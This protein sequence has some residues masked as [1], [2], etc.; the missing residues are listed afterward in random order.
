MDIGTIRTSPGNDVV[1]KP[2]LRITAALMVT[3]ASQV[4]CAE[5][6]SHVGASMSQAAAADEALAIAH[7]RDAEALLAHVDD[8]VMVGHGMESGKEWF[9][10]YFRPEDPASSFWDH[11]ITV[12]AM[13]PSGTAAEMDGD[14]ACYPPQAMWAANWISD[15][16]TTDIA[17]PIGSAVGVWSE[18]STESPLLTRAKVDALFRLLEEVNADWQRVTIVDSEFSGYVRRS[19]IRSASSRFLC[20]QVDDD[21]WKITDYIFY[22]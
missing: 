5:E 4:S 21:S 17:Y 7:R 22:E 9:I 2:G 3:L 8:Q 11:L 6:P 13:T 18:P 1:G 10:R 20:I 14:V 15:G 19:D 12:L 16:Q